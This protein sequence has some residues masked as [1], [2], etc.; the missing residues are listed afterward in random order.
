MDFGD[1]DE[2]A[3]VVLC[4]S[5]SFDCADPVSCLVLQLQ[6]PRVPSR[7]TLGTS[8]YLQVPPLLGGLPQ[9]VDWLVL[10]QR[11]EGLEES[12]VVRVV[13]VVLDL[14]QAQKLRSGKPCVGGGAGGRLA[15]VDFCGGLRGEG[16]GIVERGVAS[17]VAHTESRRGRVDRC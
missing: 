2:L 4:A 9:L 12:V 1:D 3:I 16:D 5:S 15:K 6:V 13:R 10:G 7:Y 17:R 11:G 14:G 8:R